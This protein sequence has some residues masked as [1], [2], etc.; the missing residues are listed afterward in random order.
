L[1]ALRRGCLAPPKPQ[2]DEIRS[3]TEENWGIAKKDKL[4]IVICIA[5]P[6]PLALAGRGALAVLM[7]RGQ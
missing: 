1:A 2:A 5:L 7:W 4:G 3:A 6:L